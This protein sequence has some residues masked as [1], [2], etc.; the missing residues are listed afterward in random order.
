MGSWGG[1][2]AGS[3]SGCNP[4]SVQRLLTVSS[5]AATQYADLVAGTAAGNRQI[6]AIGNSDISCGA[7]GTTYE[8]RMYAGSGGRVRT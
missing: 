1:C 2:D 6:L 5:A 3:A 4:G 7:G 8:G